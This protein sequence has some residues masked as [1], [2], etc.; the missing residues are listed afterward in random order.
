M[1]MHVSELI[2]ARVELSSPSGKCL[3]TIFANERPIVL[4]YEA[5]KLQSYLELIVRTHVSVDAA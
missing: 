2:L 5:D 1:R 3:G 4:V